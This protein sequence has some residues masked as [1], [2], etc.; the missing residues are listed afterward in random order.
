DIVATAGVGQPAPLAAIAAS[1]NVAAVAPLATTRARVHVNSAK[2]DVDRTITV[3]DDGL[4]KKDP[5]ELLDRGE[6]RSDAAAFRAV[7]K[8]PDLVIVSDTLLTPLV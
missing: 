1:K 7:L 6:Y 8:H 5:P 2:R 3:F 4:V